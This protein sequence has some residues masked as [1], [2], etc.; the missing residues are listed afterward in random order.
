[1][2]DRASWYIDS[3]SV[4]PAYK[5]SGGIV[6]DHFFQA[7]VL[8]LR[9]DYLSNPVPSIYQGI[10]IGKFSGGSLGI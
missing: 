8:T 3:V 4:M 6:S 7:T 10:W 2:Q 5:V 1:M 9:Q